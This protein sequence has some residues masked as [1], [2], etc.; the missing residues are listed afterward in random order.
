MGYQSLSLNLSLPFHFLFSLV[1]LTFTAGA[2]Y[3]AL[4]TGD[5]SFSEFLTNTN[6]QHSDPKL[7][8]III[9]KDDTLLS[10]RDHLYL[11][12]GTQSLVEALIP[13]QTRELPLSGLE[14]SFV[15]DSDDTNGT[16]GGDGSI[17]KTGLLLESSSDEED[18][19]IS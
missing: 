8:I 1:F 18:D 15:V 7:L 10:W 16:G 11:Y 9:G 4:F 5:V 3:L 2:W 19:L 14:W 6:Q 12:F 13:F 17:E